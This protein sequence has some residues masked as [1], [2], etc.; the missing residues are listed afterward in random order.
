M[1]LL[2]VCRLN[3]LSD[4]KTLQKSL[5]ISYQTL[6]SNEQKDDPI[7]HRYAKVT[8]SRMRKKNATEKVDQPK[9]LNSN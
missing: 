6:Q 9:N 2:P 5:C 3:S 4:E 8:E 1:H 7:L